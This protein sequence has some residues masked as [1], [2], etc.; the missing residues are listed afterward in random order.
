MEE[1]FQCAGMKNANVK[2][3]VRLQIV[4]DIGQKAF[5][6][7]P[8]LLDA[9]PTALSIFVVC[10]LS[11]ENPAFVIPVSSIPLK[12]ADTNY[13]IQ[14]RDSKAL[15]LNDISTQPGQNFIVISII[16]F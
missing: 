16:S 8:T 10:F 7:P 15:L 4:F 12:N 9:S 5:E 3:Y 6:V 2:Q 1:K 13:C 11:L 14:I